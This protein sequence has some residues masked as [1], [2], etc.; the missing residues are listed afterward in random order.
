[1]YGYLYKYLAL[2][3]KLSLPG[4]GSFTT[5]QVPSRIDFV[6]KRLYP[7]MPVIRFSQGTPMA[8]KYFY[9]FIA[10][11][12]KIDELEAIQRFNEFV[13]YLKEQFTMNG[14]VDFP[15]IGRLTK[16]FSNT[17]SF[18]PINTIQP[19]LPDLHAERVVRK[20]AG[21]TIKVGE[22]EVSS[23]DTDEEPMTEEQKEKNWKVHA[24]IL[25]ILAAMAII[26][27]YLSR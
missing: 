11:G 23:L 22:E 14:F 12:L 8:D 5:D 25:A 9:R 13:F 17:Y 6:N 4:I 19:F 1:M 21:H 3:K 7:Y 20:Y 16:Q 18:K 15:G 24:L 26:Y 10:N 2:H 27:Y